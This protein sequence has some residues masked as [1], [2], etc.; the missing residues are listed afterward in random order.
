MPAPLTHIVFSFVF[1][2]NNPG[3]FDQRDFIVGSVAPDIRYLGVARR[4]D[5][6]LVSPTFEQVYKA[7]T[8]F[9]AGW[10][11]HSLVDCMFDSY[12]KK[13][14]GLAHI[15]PLP[16][17]GLFLKILQDSM[18]FEKCNAWKDIATYFDGERSV[19]KA[20]ETEKKFPRRKIIEWHN[21][22]TMLIKNRLL[23]GKEKDFIACLLKTEGGKAMLQNNIPIPALLQTSP[24]KTETIAHLGEEFLKKA[25]QNPN[26]K[27]FV[28]DFYVF[29]IKTIKEHI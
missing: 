22:I 2:Q 28:T 18:L 26:V 14:G 11:F 12:L 5:T 13:H 4:S 8:S 27:P 15:M 19:L 9:E 29:M 21:L 6:H 17:G 1:L 25:A 16:G 7:K 10:I 23:I 20:E 24:E 3:V